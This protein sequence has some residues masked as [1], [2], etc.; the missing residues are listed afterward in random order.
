HDEDEG[1]RKQHWNGD[2]DDVDHECDTAAR[3][4]AFEQFRVGDRVVGMG[5]D[6]DGEAD[7]SRSAVAHVQMSSLGILL[8]CKSGRIQ[9]RRSLCWMRPDLQD[10]RMPSEDI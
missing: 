6:L 7:L 10:S 5:L 2:D 9:H 1:C 4:Y 8:S 3:Q